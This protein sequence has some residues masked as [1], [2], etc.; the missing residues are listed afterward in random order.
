MAL[1]GI[2]VWIFVDPS[3]KKIR[4]FL[5]ID[6]SKSTI[7]LMPRSFDL[8]SHLDPGIERG[9]S[10]LEVAAIVVLVIGSVLAIFGFLGCCGAMKQVKCLLTI[11][12][13]R[14]SSI[15]QTNVQR[16]KINVF[17]FQYASIVVAIM[18]VEI[19]ITIYFFAFRSKFDD[20]LIPKLQETITNNYEGPL[21]LIESLKRPKPSSISLAWDFI[22]FNVSIEF[23]LINII[24][25][26]LFSVQM[27]WS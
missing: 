21:G 5:P 1:I 7:I 8:S 16:E 10:Y 20:Q 11:V 24:H 15:D 22:M 18:L 26:C 13:F 17:W 23:Q 19:A 6:S 25:F 12:N 3:F 2:G 14:F 4:E 27:L 9:I